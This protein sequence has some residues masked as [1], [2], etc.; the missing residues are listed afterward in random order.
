MHS[1]RQGNIS[2]KLVHIGFVLYD[3]LTKR[4]FR[5]LGVIIEL[6]TGQDGVTRVAIAKMVNYNKTSYLWRGIKHLIQIELSVN[7]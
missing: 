5:K 4:V 2:E 1:S 6:L 7:I 3:K